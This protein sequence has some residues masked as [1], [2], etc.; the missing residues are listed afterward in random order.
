LIK[1]K[2]NDNSV[3]LIKKIDL[4]LHDDNEDINETI[5]ENLFEE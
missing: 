4:D 5:I 1:K 2:S 3:N